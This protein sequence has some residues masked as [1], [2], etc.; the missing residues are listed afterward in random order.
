VDDVPPAVRRTRELTGNQRQRCLL[1]AR[2]ALPPAAIAG[3][4]A[5]LLHGAGLVRDDDG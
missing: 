1:V 3:R 2:Y 4:S 5:A